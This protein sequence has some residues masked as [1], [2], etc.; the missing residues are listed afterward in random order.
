MDGDPA[1]QE[2][3][4]VSAASRHPRPPRPLPGSGTIRISSPTAGHDDEPQGRAL[5]TSLYASYPLKLLSPGPLPSQPRNLGV[6]YTLAYGGG[7]VGGDTISLD[8][9]VGTGSGLVV[10]TQGSTKVYRTRVR[11]VRAAAATDIPASQTRQRLIA[12]VASHGFLLLLPD[13]VSPFGSSSFAQAQRFMLPADGTASVLVLD[14]VNNGRG[15]LSKSA[16]SP[17]GTQE[18]WGMDRYSSTNEI[19]IG[20]TLAM[21]ESL[22]LDNDAALTANGTPDARLTR[23]AHRLAPY[24]VYCTVL[25]AGPRMVTL[26]RDLAHLAEAERQMKSM[27]PAALVWSFSEV[28]GEK[29]AF[30]CSGGILRLAAVETEDIRKWLRV[31]LERGGIKDMTGDSLWSRVI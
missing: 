8:L 2:R 3:I 17:A 22:V 7:L 23:V 28:F 13:P 21:R 14:W 11:S 9:E 30:Q 10:L 6:V 4:V 29:S 12:R 24:H 5:F 31:A 25:I 26:L 19:W 16:G 15:A 20:G 1:T 27:R 18:I